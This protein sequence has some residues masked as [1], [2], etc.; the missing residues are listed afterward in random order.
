M[1]KKELSNKKKLENYLLLDEKKIP[2]LL[3]DN[4]NGKTIMLSGAFVGCSPRLHRFNIYLFDFVGVVR[5]LHPT[6]LFF[7][8]IL[9]NGALSKRYISIK[10]A[11]YRS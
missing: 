8:P 6:N 1:E 4:N 2:F 7:M 10:T 9:L 5:G 3:D 11:P